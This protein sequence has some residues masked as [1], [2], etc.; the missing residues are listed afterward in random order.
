M[1]GGVGLTVHG[2]YRVATEKTLFAKPETGIGLFPDV[3]STHVLSRVNGGMPMG[4]YIGLTG[5]RLKAA[6]LIY[7]GLATHFV[8][9]ERLGA[10]EDSLARLPSA[11]SV[12]VDRAILEAGGGAVADEST[13]TLAPRADAIHRCFSAST[14]ERI[15]AALTTEAGGSGAH[16]EWA[17]ATLKTLLKQSPT[18]VKITFEA[19]RRAQTMDIWKTLQMEYRMV[20]RC[21]RPQPQS[22]FYEGVRA[23]L[24]DKDQSP[25]WSPS[26][27]EQVSDEAVEGFFAPLGADHLLGE[28]VATR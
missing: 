23:V 6:D 17:A 27:L 28:L 26:T 19:I 13:A 16:A 25:V 2:K 7:S 21:M 8:P 5:A 24:V 11:D 1:G 12:A 3:G 20:Q 14:V 22:D 4:L 10:L 15:V 9:S 18:S